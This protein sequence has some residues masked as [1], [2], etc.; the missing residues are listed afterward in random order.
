M[1]PVHL[2]SS[3]SLVV[4]PSAQQHFWVAWE[5]P[6]GRLGPLGCGFS[7]SRLQLRHLFLLSS[8]LAQWHLLALISSCLSQMK[9]GVNEVETESQGWGFDGCY[10]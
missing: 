5:R 3:N 1:V 4:S 8:R 10:G 2:T 7:A 6:L 9:C